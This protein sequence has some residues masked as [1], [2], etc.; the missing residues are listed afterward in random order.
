MKNEI[1]VKGAREQNLKNI[2]VTIPRNQFVVMTGLSGSGKSSLAFETIYK[3]GQRRY[4]ESLSAYAR[5]F[6]GNMEKPD[7]DSIE[8]LSPAISIDQKTTNRN[9]RSTVGTVTE[10]YDYLRLLFA[11]VGRPI[12]PTHGIEI[13]A[14]S[15]TQ[16]VNRLLDYPER[17]RM[18]I[19]APVV[20]GAKGTHVKVFEKLRNDG[21]VRVRVNGENYDLEEVPTLEKNK[22]HSIEVVIDRVALKEGIRTRLSDSIETSLKLGEGK[23][24]VIVDEE[25]LVFSEHFACPHCDFSVGKLQ[26][27]MFSF[28][29][30][31]GACSCCSGLG[32]EKEIDIDIVIKDRSKSIS[33]GAIKGWDNPHAYQRKMLDTT[34]AHY[35]ISLEKPFDDLTKKEQDTV[36]YG[37]DDEI[38]FKLVSDSG[39]VHE[40]VSYYEGVIGNLERRHLET[41]SSY[42]RDWIESMMSERT[43]R[44]CKGT[45]LSVEA[46]SVKI[47]SMNI[48]D[49][50]DM[51]IKEAYSATENMSL[52]EKEKQIAHLV[53]KEIKERLSFLINVGLEYLTLDRSA[54]TLSGGESQRI[55]LATQIGSRLSG[56]LYVLDE[57]SI[58][59]HQRDNNRLIE[60][61]KSMRDL[62]NTLIVVE[63]D[64]D[65]MLACDHLI[66]IGPRAGVQ[67]GEI[68]SQGTPVEVMNDDNSITGRYLAGKEQIFLPDERKVGNGNF[69]EVIGATENNLKNVDLKLPMGVLNVVSGVSGSG[70]STLINQVLYAAIASKLYKAKAK[71]GAHK[72]VR[73]LEHVERIVDID[74]SP[75]G[76]TPRSNPATYTG[77]FDDIRD[78]FAST[79]E[80]KLRGYAKGRFSF[81]VK[82]GRCGACSGDGVIKIEMHFLPDVYVECEECEGTRFNRETL[83]VKYRD[84]SIADVLKMTAAEALA[85]FANHPKISRK[86]QTIVDVGLDYIQLGQSSSTLSGGEAQR[87]KLAAELDSKVKFKP[88]KTIYILDEPTT[89]LHVDDVKRFIKVIQSMVEVGATIIIIEHNL[90]VIKMADHVVDLGP[91][92]GNGGGMIIAQ[93][94]PEEVAEVSESHTAQYLKKVLE[95]DRERQG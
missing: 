5:Q 24:I 7:V 79:N 9:P 28:N 47:N 63:H 84:K 4:V 54:G 38:F 8:G 22:K 51:S 41:T 55:R 3:E 67:G 86:L 39:Q 62:G 10:I 32:V 26:P 21:Y 36:L 56:V 64:E 48:A 33:E 49:F 69:V 30:P 2:D 13:T 42:I 76:R 83:E 19:L 6:L 29:T 94:T 92:G 27:R 25:E 87:V 75:I 90:D 72:A 43:C 85:F 57:P 68:V 93:G 31:F 20:S 14:T 16:M 73:G 91:E 1:V 88:D 46:R 61:L 81:N 82:G 70:K 45:R 59:L 17:T 40:K 71:P 34:C 65:T 95:R 60:T 50:T 89:G 11:R 23:V 35:G 44:E 18:Q 80:A 12:C 52:T 66:D 37:S 78:L 58:G 15:A 74:Q 77:V 53:S